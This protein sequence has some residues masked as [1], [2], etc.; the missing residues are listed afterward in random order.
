MQYVESDNIE[1]HDKLPSNDDVYLSLILAMVEDISEPIPITLL[2]NGVLVSGL[3]VKQS[4]HYENFGNGSLAKKLGEFIEEGKAE[5]Q[6]LNTVKNP[7][8]LH[9]RN[10]KVLFG[11]HP[12]LSAHGFVRIRISSVDGYWFANYE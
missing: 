5:L 11:N 8:Y 6:D 4:E 1:K 7:S 3:L 12:S 2:V 10:A 9:L